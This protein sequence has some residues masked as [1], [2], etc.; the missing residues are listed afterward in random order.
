MVQNRKQSCFANLD[1]CCSLQTK[2]STPPKYSSKNISKVTPKFFNTSLVVGN[3][4]TCDRFESRTKISRKQNLN[5]VLGSNL[6]Q[7]SLHFSLLRTLKNYFLY[8]KILLEI[9]KFI[10]RNPQFQAT[11]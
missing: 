1:Y 7:D 9:L 5:F 8:L 10:L 6:S 11:S 3:G 4:A 2:N